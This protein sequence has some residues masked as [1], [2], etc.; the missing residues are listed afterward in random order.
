MMTDLRHIGSPPKNK[1]VAS[2]RL[3]VKKEPVDLR[4]YLLP[5]IRV[6]SRAGLV[7]LAGGLLAASI[8]ALMQ[9]TPFPVQKVEVRGTK[10]LTHEEIIAL[11]GVAP[12]QNLLALRLK[13]IGQQVSSNPWVASVRVQRFFPGT[14]AVSISER[15]PVAV[16]NMGLLY[17][18]DDKG[19][20]FKPL[21]F[22]DS[23]D[24]PVVSGIAEDDLSNDP[25]TTKEALKTACNLIEALKQHGSFI[26]ADVSEIHYDRGHGFTLYTTAGALPVKIGTDD[27]DKKLQRFA[28]I[29]QNL[30]TH[31][32]GLQYIDLDYSDRIV[33]K[34]G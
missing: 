12:G 5:L 25:A 6:G 22:G 33:V 9:T 14:I 28:R 15:Q 2:N 10:R 21:S 13:S 19:E 17:Y 29:Y 31:Q 7:L 27:F 4:K 3:K 23:L 30:M 24:F 16:I 26:L 8:H 34:K 11:T 32:P 18:L 20:P 1:K